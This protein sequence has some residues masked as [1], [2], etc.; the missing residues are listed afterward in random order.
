MGT[1][2]ELV[3]RHCPERGVAF[4]SEGD[5]V[6]DPLEKIPAIESVVCDHENYTLRG[7]GDDSVTDAI[8]AIA[9]QGIQVTGFRTDLPNLEDVFLKLTGHRIRD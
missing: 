9:T 5:G 6:R 1:P 2:D 3:Q 8:H 4:S 7:T